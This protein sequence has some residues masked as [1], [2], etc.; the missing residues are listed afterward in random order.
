MNWVPG[1]SNKVSTDRGTEAEDVIGSGTD[2]IDGGWAVSMI[3]VVGSKERQ[4][5]GIKQE[6]ASLSTR[7]HHRL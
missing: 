3:S 1:Q 7:I 6:L 4:R 2:T 5:Q